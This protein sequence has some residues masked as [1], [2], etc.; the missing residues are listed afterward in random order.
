MHFWS[1][2]STCGIFFLMY[3][4]N[5]KRFSVNAAPSCGAEFSYIRS[6]NLSSCVAIG[7]ASA[8]SVVKSS[9]SW[10]NIKIQIVRVISLFFKLW[11]A[12]HCWTECHCKDMGRWGGFSSKTEGLQM[13]RRQTQMKIEAKRRFQSSSQPKCFRLSCYDSEQG[14]SRLCE[15]LSLETWR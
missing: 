7:P 2:S 13:R 12:L 9:I 6:G 5:Q 1:I 10:F 15:H 3:R 14:E 4:L 11:A 8:S